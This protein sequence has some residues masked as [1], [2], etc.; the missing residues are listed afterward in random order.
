MDLLKNRKLVLGV[1]VGLI[2]IVSIGVITIKKEAIGTNEANNNID[3]LETS[4]I[5]TQSTTVDENLTNPKESSTLPIKSP[6]M[7]K[8]ATPVMVKGVGTIT[9]DGKS[10]KINVSFPKDGG[11]ITGTASGYCKGNIDGTFDKT[12][13]N[14]S[15]KV[16]GTCTHWSVTFPASGTFTGLVSIDSKIGE[17][18]FS[19][20]GG[21]YTR[22]GTWKITIE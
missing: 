8:N 15:G 7:V 12:T 21:Q 20:S 18:P 6:E 11:V 10:T 9:I 1:V 22:N 16:E 4:T 3:S 13:G 2:T 5:D 14:A 17:G 19:G